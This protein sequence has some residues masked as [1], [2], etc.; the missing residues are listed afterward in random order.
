MF[1][2]VKALAAEA[3]PH[4]LRWS[5]RAK[6]WA[7]MG[8]GPRNPARYRSEVWTLV[9][10][11]P[12]KKEEVFLAAFKDGHLAWKAPK[13]DKPDSIPIDYQHCKALDPKFLD[14]R[15]LEKKLAKEELGPNQVGQFDFVLF[16]PLDSDCLGLYD[17]GMVYRVIEGIPERQYGKA[18]WVVM[19]DTAKLYFDGLTGRF[20]GRFPPEEPAD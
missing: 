10:G 4:A 14:T 13:T 6:L 2:S 9:Y 11:D 19:N 1:H 15:A 8:S 17:V 7:A 12:A 20:L 3:K 18:M 5:K 16:R